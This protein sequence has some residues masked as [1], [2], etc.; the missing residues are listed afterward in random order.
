[1]EGS[2]IAPTAPA[3]IAALDGA[4]RRH[5]APC[6]AGEM[7]WRQWGEGMAVVLLH[8][9]YGS[10]GHWLRNIPALATR[11]RVIVPD[12]PGLGESAM[13]PPTDHLDDISDIVFD[14]LTTVLAPGAPFH[15]VGF[16]FGGHL[17]GRIAVRAGGR[18][19][20]LT[21]VGAGGLGLPR[22]GRAGAALG[23][24]ARGM[25]DSEIAALQRDNLAK[26]MFHDPAK[27]DEAALWLQ[28]ENVKRGR[29]KSIPFA[30][31]DRLAQALPLIT[32][33]LAGIWGEFDITAHPH[34]D[35]R[36]ALLHKYQPEAPFHV[37]AGAGHWVQYEAAAEFNRLL[38]DFLDP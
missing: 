10:W 32:A 2:N 31:G 18:L 34:L 19:R 20:S 1:M 27:I 6:G 30:Q 14:G 23:R 21:L 35:Q 5:L 24:V 13:P 7:V 38:R 12:L 11:Y 9:G 3:E 15:L 37:V 25:S 26:F 17:A 33:P 29:F 22:V 36:A 8:G 28:I 4:A 16:S